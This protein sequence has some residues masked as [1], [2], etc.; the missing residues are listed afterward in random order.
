[1]ETNQPILIAGGGIGGCTLGIALQQRGIPFRIFERQDVLQ[2]VGAG[3]SLWP[4]ATRALSHLGLAEALG[5]LK[6]ARYDGGMFNPRGDVLARDSS[7]TMEQRFG[8]PLIVVHRAELLAEL[9]GRI[10][11]EHLVTGARCARFQQ[12]DDGVALELEDGSTHRGAALIGADGIHSA[13]RR[14]LGLPCA[15]RYAGY[16][17]WRGIIDIESTGLPADGD[18]YGFYLGEGTQI[19]LAPVRGGRL[20]WFATLNAPR[21]TRAGPKGNREELL[22]RFGHWPEA[23]R[24]VFEAMPE[25]HILRND[26]LDLPPI[27]RWGQDR[28]SLLGDAAHA[29]TPNLGQGACIAIEDAVALARHLDEAEDAASG[30]RAYEEERLER[31]NRVVR[32]S[33]RFGQALQLENPV[34]CWLR[35]QAMKLGQPGTRLE[36]LAWL[37]DHDASTGAAWKRP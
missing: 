5:A 19:G 29:T 8:M 36:R 35:D 17:G 32:M 28:V 11:P 4:N 26:I 18:W 33:W 31:A 16:T 10:A 37:L 27:S 24:R 30:L 14:C 12:D 15:T 7:V 13:V 1:M 25:E 9:V 21:G 6:G 20:Y 23:V 22:R 2:E 3:L 34:L